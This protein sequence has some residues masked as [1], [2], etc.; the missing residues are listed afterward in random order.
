MHRNLYTCTRL[1]SHV[2]RSFSVTP[3]LWNKIDLTPFEKS[4]WLPNF[5]G[6]IYPTSEWQLSWV[7]PFCDLQCTDLGLTE[8]DLQKAELLP[9]E[10]VFAACTAKMDEI[11]KGTWELDLNAGK[12][13]NVKDSKIGIF[14]QK[15]LVRR[16]HINRV[17]QSAFGLLRGV[18]RLQGLF[19]EDLSVAVEREG[20]DFVSDQLLLAQ[21]LA[22]C[23]FGSEG[24][25]YSAQSGTFKIAGQEIRGTDVHVFTRTGDRANRYRYLLIWDDKLSVGTSGNSDTTAR[26]LEN[27]VA[28]IIGEMM[29]VHYQNAET[30]CAPCE[31]YAI[32]LIGHMVAFFKMEMTAEQIKAVCEDGAIPDPKVQV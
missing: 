11:G 6:N 12:D 31:V 1:P 28:E 17:V 20:D 3:A 23:G 32:R 5:F 14:V 7:E 16:R 9:E 2:S 21:L 18:L 27:S 26:W 19:K 15:D 30:G 29:S 8:D 13:L 10:K 4:K 25:M 24:F 22:L